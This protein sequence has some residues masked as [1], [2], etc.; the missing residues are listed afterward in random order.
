M[1]SIDTRLANVRLE[2]IEEA[3]EMGY[4]HAVEPESFQNQAAAMEVLGPALTQVFDQGQPVATLSQVARQV[5]QT[6][7][8]R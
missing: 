5:E 2:L 6:Q 4:H 3:I 8:K 7:N 1:R